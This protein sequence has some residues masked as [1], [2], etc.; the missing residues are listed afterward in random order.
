MKY[1]FEQENEKKE[2]TKQAVNAK[3]KQ[4]NSSQHRF[5][6]NPAFAIAPQR[7]FFSPYQKEIKP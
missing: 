5:V 1:R 4:P 7:P 6:V 3:R 2:L